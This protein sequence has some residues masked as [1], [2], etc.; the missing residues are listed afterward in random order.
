MALNDGYAVDA[1]G[2]RIYFPPIGRPRLVPTREE[3]AKFNERVLWCLVIALLASFAGMASLIFVPEKSISTNGEWLVLIFGSRAIGA[4]VM[5]R[6]W[7]VFPGN[8][9]SYGRF[10]IATLSGESKSSLILRL[11]LTGAAA[12]ALIGLAAWSA[13]RLQA[14][15]AATDSWKNAERLILIPMLLA[16]VP[17]CGL[18][19][20]RILA[21][22]RR[23]RGS[24][25]TTSSA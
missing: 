4:S 19:A 7:P 1:Q 9:I 20:S 15:W 18:H 8:R 13:I 22:L 10:V 5:A 12:A 2:R 21:A 17:F 3:E 14:E 16:I 6:R 25:A 24:A 11:L 23:Q